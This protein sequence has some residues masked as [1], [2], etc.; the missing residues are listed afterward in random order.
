VQAS[1]TATT[2][3][4]RARYRAENIGRWYSG[5]VH[6]A[7]TNAFSLG[8]IGFAISRVSQPSWKELLVI[9]I[10][11]LIAN[12]AEYFGHR[13]PMHYP[14]RGLGIIFRRHTIEHHH[15][16]THDLMSYE[17]SRDFKMV[18]FPPVMLLFF[19]GGIAT[20]IALLLFA[21][22]SANAGWIFVA[23]GV[24]Y[25]LTY[26]WLHFAYHLPKD[27]FIGRLRVIQV[28]RRHHRAHHNLGLMG[29]WNFNI[30][31]P[32]CDRLF[33]TTYRNE[34]KEPEPKVA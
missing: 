20:P 26:E 29:R 22:F 14:Q 31:F 12:V 10:G 33:G 18:L 30:T 15:F 8:V 5:W 21:L 17:S 27:T 25:Y 13:G 6:F 11:F 32:I 4:Y 1:D 24:G 34:G 28:L 3:A 19:L 7:F 23:V 16:F 2:A 9:P